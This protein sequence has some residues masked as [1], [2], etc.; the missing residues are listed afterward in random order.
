MHLDPLS[1]SRS[2]GVDS[3]VVHQ[4]QPVRLGLFPDLYAGGT[5]RYSFKCLYRR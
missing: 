2:S 1:M 3:K 4:V 5:R